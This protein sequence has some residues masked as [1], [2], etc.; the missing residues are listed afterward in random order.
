MAGSDDGPCSDSALGLRPNLR[1]ALRWYGP[2]SGAGPAPRGTAPSGAP[3][4]FF[5]GT[6]LG[7]AAHTMTP[8]RPWLYAA[9]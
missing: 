8:R 4:F 2:N 1:S 5:Q 6:R 9:T 3:V 7:A